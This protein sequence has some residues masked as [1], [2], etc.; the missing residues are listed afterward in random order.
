MGFNAAINEELNWYALAES[1]KQ[2]RRAKEPRESRIEGRKAR[3]RGKVGR[4]EK[5]QQ[6]RGVRGRDTNT[7]SRD[8]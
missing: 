3:G 5:Q 2:K 1:D 7:Q 6:Y 8:Q 4:Y